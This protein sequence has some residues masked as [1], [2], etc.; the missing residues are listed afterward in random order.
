[1]KKKI[2]NVALQAWGGRRCCGLRDGA[3]LMV[4]WALGRR[5]D[6]GATGSGIAQVDDV[7]SLGTV[8]GAHRRRLREDDIVVGSRTASWAWG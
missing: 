5:G 4:S 1:M 3:G 7:M 8:R 2:F 6:D